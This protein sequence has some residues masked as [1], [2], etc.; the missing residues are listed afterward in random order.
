MI[1]T[2]IYQHVVLPKWEMPSEVAARHMNLANVG[3]RQ[4][5][6]AQAIRQHEETRERAQ[7][8]R[9]IL[10]AAAAGR[11]SPDETYAALV[12]VDPALAQGVREHAQAQQ[13]K[14]QKFNQALENDLGNGFAAIVAEPNRTKWPG[15][16]KGLR[17]RKTVNPLYTGSPEGQAFLKNYPEEMPP[18]EKIL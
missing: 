7:K 18:E 17:A 2:S 13:E 5:L 3:Q 12:P 16:W 14:I 4:T 1:D 8:A 11:L 9:E 6:Q 15:L 10:G